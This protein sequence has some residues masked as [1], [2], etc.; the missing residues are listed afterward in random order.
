MCHHSSS[1]QLHEDSSVRAIAHS[2]YIYDRFEN[3]NEPVDVVLEA[4]AKELAL[5]DYL[6]KFE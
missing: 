3:F 5:L 6:K 2:D 1:R 4:K